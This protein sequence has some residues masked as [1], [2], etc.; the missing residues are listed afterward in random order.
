[1]RKLAREAVI[2]MLLAPPTLCV[3]AFIYLHHDA[4]KPPMPVVTALQ[5]GPIFEPRTPIQPIAPPQ[6]NI[7][8]HFVLH[9]PSAQQGGAYVYAVQVPYVPFQPP[10]N[11][12]LA[13]RSLVVALI[14]FPVGISL[15]VLYR[16][17]RF[18]I[19]G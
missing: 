15:W 14:G 11:G 7:D 4:H 6:Y 19:T 1:M 5:P 10:T 8:P 9:P 17:V 18:A 12:A 3:A 16:L 13:V 2:F